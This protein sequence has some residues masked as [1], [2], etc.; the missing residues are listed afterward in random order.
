MPNIS[1]QSGTYL[2][3]RIYGVEAT[4]GGWNLT[5][6]ANVYTYITSLS[7]KLDETSIAVRARPLGSLC[8]E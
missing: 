3:G 1:A 6:A 4:A 5:L 7:G 2:I 8:L